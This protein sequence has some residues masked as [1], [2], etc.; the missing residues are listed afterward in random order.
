M[1][2]KLDENL[3]FHLGTE[4][5][6]LGHDVHTT[7]QEDLAGSADSDIFAATQKESRFL[8]IQDLDFS[9]VRVPR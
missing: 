4:L 7:L 3:P 6:K 5:A 8:I 2:I 9:D 1:K